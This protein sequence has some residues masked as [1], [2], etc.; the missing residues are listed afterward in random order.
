MSIY[1]VLAIFTS[2]DIFFYKYQGAGND[3]ILLDA[4]S[5]GFVPDRHLVGRMCDRHFGIGA[6]GLMVIRKHP[7][8]DFEM[9]YF[10][11]D[12]LPG[13]MCGNGGRCILQFAMELG[14][15]KETP[16]FMAVDGLHEGRRNEDGSISLKMK[17]VNGI[18]KVDGYMVID[19]GS[20]H[21][22][23]GVDDLGSMNIT[24]E[25]RRIRNSETFAEDGINVNFISSLNGNLHVRTYERGVE[26]ETLS[27]GT[28]VTAAA[29]W[30]GFLHQTDG[31]HSTIVFTKGG[32][33]R[34]DFEKQNDRFI[35]IWLTGPAAKVFTGTFQV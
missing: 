2:M 26:E 6:D 14:Y 17:D 13:T 19:T 35:N 4:W 8:A 31:R 21:C 16:T 29:I 7:D 5:N 11:S 33:L 24:Q 1:G 25:G 28:G 34:V 23:V 20:P 9:L 12:G 10:N 15:A 3:F 18:S 30:D 32:Q 27:C 22:L